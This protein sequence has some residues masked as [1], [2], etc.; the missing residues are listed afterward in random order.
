V[1]QAELAKLVSLATST[2][3]KALE[4]GS[5]DELQRELNKL[6][7]NLSVGFPDVSKLKKKPDFV[8]ALI[9]TRKKAFE[10]N[11]ELE[12]Q[13]A[14]EAE[15]LACGGK[16]TKENRRVKSYRESSSRRNSKGGRDS[17]ITDVS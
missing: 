9:A 8:N 12:S 10:V 5:I 15:E 16:S 2:S 6:K 3:P 17:R 14:R 11:S 4:K 7:D 1:T 13:F